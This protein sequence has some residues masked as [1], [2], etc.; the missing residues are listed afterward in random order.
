MTAAQLFA[1]ITG[2][3][4]TFGDG[5]TVGLGDLSSTTAATNA[6]TFSSDAWITSANTNTGGPAAGFYY[7]IT[8]MTLKG[9]TAGGT[10]QLADPAGIQNLPG[11]SIISLDSHNIQPGAG[12]GAASVDAG[13]WRLTSLQ[14]VPLPAALPL[15]LAGLTGLGGLV[16]RRRAHAA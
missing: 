7:L 10:F 11:P 8:G 2:L 14:P 15:L 16:R 12:A 3:S 5:I 13:Y 1:S 9:T 4:F 6:S